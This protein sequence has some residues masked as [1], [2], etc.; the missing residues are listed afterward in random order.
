MLVKN[1]CQA[2]RPIIDPDDLFGRKTEF[3]SVAQNDQFDM[4]FYDTLRY[5]Q[6]QYPVS[7]VVASTK[8][9]REKALYRFPEEA[10]DHFVYYWEHLTTEERAVLKKVAEGKKV[11]SDKKPELIDLEQKALIKQDNNK[12]VIFS[13]AFEGF[14][15]KVEFSEVKEDLSRFFS[16][17][18]KSLVSIANY[19]IDKAIALKK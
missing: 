7:Y 15:K 17:N 14:V 4:V 8:Q 3:D 13:S 18:T 19:C 10:F 2:S 9:I 6:Q 12:N 1:P 11:N 5:Y 16:K